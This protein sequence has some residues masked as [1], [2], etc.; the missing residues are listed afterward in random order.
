MTWCR[1]IRNATFSRGTFAGVGDVPRVQCIRGVLGAD[2]DLLGAFDQPRQGLV[3]AGAVDHECTRSSREAVRDQHVRRHRLPG[4]AAA[5]DQQRVVRMK[6]VVEVEQLD[7]AAGVGERERHPGR[8]PALGP[9]Q[10]QHVRCVDGRVLADLRGDVASQGQDA[11]PQLLLAEGPG[12]DFA[13][14]GGLDLLGAEVDRL[15]QRAQVRVGAAGPELL[16]DRDVEQAGLLAGGK[17]AEQSLVLALL[18]VAVE[19]RHPPAGLRAA[20]DR[21]QPPVGELQPLALA[22]ALQ[23]VDVHAQRER[24][25]GQHRRVQPPHRRAPGRR[26]HR[27]RLRRVAVDVGEMGVAVE[28]EARRGDRLLQPHAGLERL[29]ALDG[30]VQLAQQLARLFRAVAP[31]G[32]GRS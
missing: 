30:R 10:R 28:V 5:G 6:L 19:V 11:L 1:A 17:L 23:R 32:S 15:R 29:L 25:S 7:G 2:L 26:G 9:D 24:L 3:V 27:D 18:H 4:P 21:E 8:R 22:P 12:V 13:V 31:V 16:V 20:V 14:A